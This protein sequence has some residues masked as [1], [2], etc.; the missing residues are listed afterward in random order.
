MVDALVKSGGYN[1]AIVDG[2]WDALEA[3]DLMRHI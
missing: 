2:M 3:R 1:G